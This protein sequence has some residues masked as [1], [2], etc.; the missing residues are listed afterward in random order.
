MVDWFGVVH[1]VQIDT[2]APSTRMVSCCGPPGVEVAAASPPGC[3]LPLLV[4]VSSAEEGILTAMERGGAESAEVVEEKELEGGG[5]TLESDDPDSLAGSS[6]LPPLAVV[7]VVGAE[8]LLAPALGA[9]KVAAVPDGLKV[10]LEVAPDPATP[11]L[12]RA[13]AVGWVGEGNVQ[14]VRVRARFASKLALG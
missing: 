3:G 1:Y 2:A 13:A 10:V 9:P 5:G 12:G 4:V 7:L 11:G 6:T 8:V 14:R